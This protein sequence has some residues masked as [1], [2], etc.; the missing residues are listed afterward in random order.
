MPLA[1]ESADAGARKYCGRRDGGILR[2]LEVNQA[3]DARTRGGKQIEISRE[4]R[5]A[6]IGRMKLRDELSVLDSH[7]HTVDLRVWATTEWLDFLGTHL[8]MSRLH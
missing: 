8:A 3:G 7:G 4:T 6:T 5:K 2:E 1:T